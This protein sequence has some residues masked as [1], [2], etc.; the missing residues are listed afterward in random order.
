MN[1]DKA[2]AYFYELGKSE[3]LDNTNR[4][5]RNVDMGEQPLPQAFGS[6]GFKVSAVSS[7]N[8]DFKIKSRNKN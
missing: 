3:A 4:M 8:S 2:A 7:G 5:I 6:S 1:P